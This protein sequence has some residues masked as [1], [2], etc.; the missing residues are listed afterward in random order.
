MSETR[1]P[2][3]RLALPYP[4]SVN[5]YW[6]QGRTWGGRRNT[7]VS[8]EGE[9]YR[10][11]V[12]EVIRQQAPGGRISLLGPV[13]LWLDVYPPDRRRRDLDNI[14][15]ALLDALGAAGVYADDS[16]VCD[17][18]LSRRAPHPPQGRLE[19]LLADWGHDGR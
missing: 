11:R 16:Q 15:K 17:L 18:R 3:F 2:F 9:A 5:H 14:L 19:A 6:T 8:P 7:Y 10:W 1:S 4:P 13:L 12:L